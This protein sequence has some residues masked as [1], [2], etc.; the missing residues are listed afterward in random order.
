[1]TGDTAYTDPSAANLNEEKHVVRNQTSPSQHFDGEKVHART[2][3]CDRMNSVEVVVRIRFGAGAM[4]F[5]RRSLPTVWS[6]SLQPKLASAPA[7]RSYPQLRF[8]RA[9]RTTR[10]STSAEIFGRPG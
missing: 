9:I 3:L 10:A 6:D 2:F 4:S 7:M 8:S 5:R 1:M